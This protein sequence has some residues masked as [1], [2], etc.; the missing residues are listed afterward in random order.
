MKKTILTVALMISALAAMAA[1]APTTKDSD[2]SQHNAIYYVYHRYYPVRVYTAPVV[3]YPRV[4]VAP[5]Y[6]V[7][8][9]Y[10]YRYWYPRYYYW[11]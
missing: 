10:T 1:V 6:P 8:P 4:Y 7:Y 11:R 5:V 2:G 3:V 9:V